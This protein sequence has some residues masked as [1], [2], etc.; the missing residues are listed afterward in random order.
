MKAELTLL[1]N[2][3]SKK[4]RKSGENRIILET[5]QKK[6]EQKKKERKPQNIQAASD[7]TV[8]VPTAQA[9]RRLRFTPPTN[10]SSDWI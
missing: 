7:E 4:I 6:E 10:N 9:I 2:R 5:H 1:K 8:G 3:K